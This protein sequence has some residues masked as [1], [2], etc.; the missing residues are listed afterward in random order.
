M[1]SEDFLSAVGSIANAL[2]LIASVYIY[3]ALLRQINRRDP[4]DTDRGFGAAEVAL[5]VFLIAVFAFSSLGASSAQIVRLRTLDLILNAVVAIGM[6]LFVAAFLK[7]RRFNLS[8]LTGLARLSFTRAFLTGLVLLIF[9][10]PL[11]IFA[12]WLTAR[13][14]G[15]GSSRQGIIELF[16]GSQSMEQ[17][18]I[19]IL[20]ATAIAPVAEE[21]IFRF[22]LYGVLRR[23]LGR[24]IGLIVSALLFAAVHVHLPSFAPL[25]GLDDDARHF[26]C[27]HSPCARFSRNIAA[28][29]G[30][31]R[32][33]GEDQ[34]LAQVFPR[35]NRNS[36][37][38]IGAGDDC[39]VVKFHGAKDWLLLKTDCVVE[40]V[41]FARETSARAVGWK[42]MMRALSDFA[43]MS[44]IPEF[45][46][47]TLA[48]AGKKK[49]SWV[50]ELYRGLNRAAARFDVAI[51][52]GETSETVGPTVIAVSVAGGVERDR[53]V[54]R[55]G[56]KANDDLFVTGKLGGPFRGGP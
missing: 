40:E 26:Q 5:A 1:G 50:D 52:G 15:S 2:F 53:C 39:A 11:I 22:F 44:G 14:L 6:V 28:M 24:S 47:I 49:A 25:F 12:E 55:S 20:L 56:G 19:I 51:V 9:A 18:V 42:A 43:A 30:V 35:L 54:L 36:R 8:E 34:L 33:L 38:V 48:I 41:H 23:Y 46:L 37:V 13:F 10:Y 21:F 31:L 16:S 17:R 3:V 7:L 27:H 32:E 45:A 4:I 29:T